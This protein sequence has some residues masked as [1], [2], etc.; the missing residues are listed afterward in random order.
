MPA[1]K[2][3][4]PNTAA[5]K[6][7]KP[8]RPEEVDAYIAAAPKSI[9]PKLRQLR[10]LIKDA[11]PQASEFISYKIPYYDFHGRMVYFAA[12]KDHISFFVPGKATSKFTTQLKAYRKPRQSTATIIFPLDEPLPATLITGLVKARVKE[13]TPAKSAKP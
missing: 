9:Q 11:A 3:P 5:S 7:A 12:F 4:A 2:R 13:L 8:S 6:G 10:T 1:A